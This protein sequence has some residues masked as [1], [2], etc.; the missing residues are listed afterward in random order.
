M[1][2]KIKTEVNGQEVKNCEATVNEE[3]KTDKP[4]ETAVAVPAKESRLKKFGKLCWNNRGKI[5]MA[6]G[7]ALTFV[8]MCALGKDDGG[9]DISSDEGPTE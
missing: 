9:T 4:A 5:G 8:A 1:E 3:N 2:E 7:S 6:I